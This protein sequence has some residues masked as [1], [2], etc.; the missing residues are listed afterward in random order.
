MDGL[1]TQVETWNKINENKREDSRGSVCLR[2]WKKQ[3]KK[4][5]RL[6]III[7]ETK[8]LTY[9]EAPLNA[10]LT[11][12]RNKKSVAQW[13]L[14]RKRSNETLRDVLNGIPVR[15]SNIVPTRRGDR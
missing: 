14:Y 12:E 7:Q 6:K 3:K 9:F 2:W 4:V 10:S 8:I 13:T 5:T 11:G 1:K 15:Y